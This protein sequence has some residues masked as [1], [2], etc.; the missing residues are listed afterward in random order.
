MARP[1][2][3]PVL[4]EED[5][6][7]LTRLRKSKTK[8]HRVVE[9]ARITLMSSDGLSDSNIAKALSLTQN[10]VRTWRWRFLSDGIDGL[11]DH[12]RSGKPPKYDWAQT[13]KKHPPV[14]LVIFPGQG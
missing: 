3:K 10:T 11:K 8:E 9:R 13:R 5:K 4:S 6:A 1:S 14:Q 2:Q 12:P 7:I